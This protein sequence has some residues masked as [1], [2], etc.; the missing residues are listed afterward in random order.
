M[1]PT[2]EEMTYTETN[3]RKS[4][5]M[6]KRGG[7]WVD[8]DHRDRTLCVLHEI[9]QGPSE[10][11][12]ELVQKHTSRASVRVGEDSRGDTRPPE[13]AQ[14]KAK[15]RENKQCAQLGE[16]TQYQS[17]GTAVL[18]PQERPCGRSCVR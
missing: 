3:I 16:E 8:P 2:P 15:G 10:H 9:E 13:N 6:D 7:T 4:N 17:T 12:L 5:V 11:E 14:V 1:T 18:S